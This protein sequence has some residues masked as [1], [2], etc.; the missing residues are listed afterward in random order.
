MFVYLN[1]K[2]L[3]EREAKIS[4]FDRGLLYADGLFETMRVYDMK[5]FK[6]DEHIKRLYEG[7]RF[8]KI[9]LKLDRG[10]LENAVKKLLKLNGIKNAYLRITV[11]RGPHRGKLTFDGKY[12]P[13]V[14]IHERHLFLPSRKSYINGVKVVTSRYKI[15]NSP[16]QSIKSLNYLINLFEK[17]NA[18]L[19]GAYEAILVSFNN[20]VTEGTTS[21][22]FCIRK[23]KV[24]TPSLNLNFLPG[25]TRK[26]VI[27]ICK[28]NNI[29]VE[30]NDIP[31]ESLKRFDEIFLTNSLI[32]ILPVTQVNNFKIGNGFCGE[33]TKKIM[34]LYKDEVKK[35]IENQKF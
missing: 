6:F 35:D 24:Q 10:A 15:T 13:T 4:V 14:F 16:I 18:R 9:P 2:F 11:T 19:M 32:E 20:N 34:E 21:N 5:I 27:E 12:A 8:L 17:E 30:E 25:I 3:K 23:S 31:V 1:G 28:K 7:V 26:A 33:L 29:C 22:I